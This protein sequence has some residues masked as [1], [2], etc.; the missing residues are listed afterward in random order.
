MAAERAGDGWWAAG[1][2]EVIGGEIDPLE[3]FCAKNMEALQHPGAFV[4]LIVLLVA[5]GTLYI[6]GLPGV[7]TGAGCCSS[8][9]PVLKSWDHIPC[10]GRR[11]ARWRKNEDES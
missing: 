3:A 11:A 7:G 9:V 10:H 6:H 8:W 5:D 4:A 1:V 2:R